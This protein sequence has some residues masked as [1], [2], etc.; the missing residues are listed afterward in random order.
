MK[1]RPLLRLGMLLLFLAAVLWPVCKLTLHDRSDR[2]AQTPSPVS[3]ASASDRHHDGILHATLTIQAAPC[4]LR[5]SVRQQDKVLLTEK[6]AIAPGEYRSIAEIT[7]GADLLISANWPNG[8]LHAL[9]VEVS[10]TGT[11]TPLEKTFWARQSLEDTIA[12]PD[13]FR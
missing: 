9:R 12:I 11:E 2:C 1:G 10:V 3:S 4:P 13:T 8:E 7:N 6:D 5:C